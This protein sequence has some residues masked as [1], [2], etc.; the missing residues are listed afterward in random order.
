MTVSGW[1]GR[2]WRRVMAEA[3]G[4][5]T[6]LGASGRIAYGVNVAKSRHY[7]DLGSIHSARFR[8]EPVREPVRVA[9]AAAFA[10]GACG[11]G[12]PV[13]PE[14]PVPG[15]WPTSAVVE[16]IRASL[17]NSGSGDQ[18]KAMLPDLEEVFVDS[19]RGAYP[20]HIVPFRYYW[21][22]S[23][24][25]TV[26]ICAIDYTVLVCPYELR[27]FPTTYDYDHC[28]I[29]SS[30]RLYDPSLPPPGPPGGR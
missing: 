24:G 5:R 28:D 14:I 18:A 29:H 10:A 23:A 19:G 16:S 6:H 27:S 26:G 8:R 9:L 15:A 21:S 7:A 20:P 25:I 4:N 13:G 17:H 22:R 12:S 1:I 3:R 2:A 30:Y 11:G